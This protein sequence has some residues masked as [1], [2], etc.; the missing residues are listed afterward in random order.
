M[1]I[2]ELIPNQVLLGERNYEEAL[3]LVIARAENE[4]LIFDTDFSRGGY[5]SAKRFELLKAFLSKTT[6]S[7]L[8]IV[9]LDA[10]YF[11]QYCPRLFNLL[12]NYSHLMTVYKTN[13]AAK[14][15]QDC[16]VIA[17]KQH[18]IRRFNRDQ[19]RFKFMFDDELTANQL[20]MRFNELLQETTEK[21]SHQQL[22]L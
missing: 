17:D 4:L 16:F 6:A 5:T 8:I 14:I 1:T 19:A 12:E 9:L 11:T 7:K 15:A 13:Q 20:N 21:I 10:D 18:V 22:G 2:S 3:N